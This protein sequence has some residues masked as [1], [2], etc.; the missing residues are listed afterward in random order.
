MT[1]TVMM[2]LDGVRRAGTLVLRVVL[3]GLFVAA[4]I[5]K[6]QDPS[7]F[8]QEISNY[9]LL[10]ATMPQLAA[11]LASALPA[12]ELVAGLAL[13]LGPRRWMRAG[14]AAVAVLLLGLTVAVTAAAARGLDISCGCFGTGSGRV[15]WLTV[16]RNL[17][18]LGQAIL[19][20]LVTRDPGGSPVS[21]APAAAEPAPPGV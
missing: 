5:A 12:M 1:K 7:G 6:A 9:Q 20:L 14:A 19:L 13:L 18:L 4:G 3:G 16:A 10:P 8:A 2:T 15:T 21:P 11:Q 17:G